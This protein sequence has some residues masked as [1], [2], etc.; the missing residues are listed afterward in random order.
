MLIQ[1]FDGVEG[2]LHAADVLDEFMKCTSLLLGKIGILG[3]Q[4]LGYLVWHHVLDGN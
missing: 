3:R 4:Q 2:I 1:Q